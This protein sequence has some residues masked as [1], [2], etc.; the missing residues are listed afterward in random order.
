MSNEASLLPKCLF[1]HGNP[2]SQ[3]SWAR[4][5]PL[6]DG[7]A[8]C[9]AI[10]LPGFGRNVRRDTRAESVALPA[11]A[12]A[13]LG[14]LDTLGWRE[15]CFVIGHSHGAAVAQTLAVAHPERVA[16][17]VLVASLGAPAHASYRLLNLPGTLSLARF[18]AWLFRA[19]S[20]LS[21]VQ[22]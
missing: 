16:G 2:G 5:I 18:V 13:A 6:L 15:P 12:S 20:V 17:I 19:P 9:A 8:E 11:L 14:A 3:R 10:D 21:V 1:L 22:V 7:V 4:L